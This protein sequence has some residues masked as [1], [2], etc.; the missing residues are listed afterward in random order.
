[1]EESHTVQLLVE[2]AKV[3]ISEEQKLALKSDQTSSKIKFFPTRQIT[4]QIE[5]AAELKIS[6]QSVHQSL[7]LLIVAS[8]PVRISPPPP[9]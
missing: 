8:Q 2:L 4:E 3:L 6:E 7:S 9:L 1:M 5:R